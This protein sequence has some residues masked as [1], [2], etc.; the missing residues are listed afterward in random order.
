MRLRKANSNLHNRFRTDLK[1]NCVLDRM[2]QTFNK[3]IN[4]NKFIPLI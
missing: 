1:A 4:N 3:N 2:V